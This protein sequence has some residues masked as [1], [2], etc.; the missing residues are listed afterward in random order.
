MTVASQSANHY[1][2]SVA[3]LLIFNAAPVALFVS[4]VRNGVLRRWVALVVG[5]LAAI[6]MASPFLPQGVSS[7]DSSTAVLY[8]AVAPIYACVLV[9]AAG[10]VVACV[11]GFDRWVRRRGGVM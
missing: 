5:V 9:A 6:V 1:F 3:V 8:Y 10:G 2:T 11:R 4:L 7:S